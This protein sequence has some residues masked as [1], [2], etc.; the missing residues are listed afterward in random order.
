MS[1]TQVSMMGQKGF[2]D[3][4]YGSLFVGH[5]TLFGSFSLGAVYYTLG[6]ITLVDSSNVSSTVS[7]EKDYSLAFNYSEEFFGLLGTGLSLKYLNSKLVD[8]VSASAF[9]FDAGIQSRIDEGKLALGFAVLNIGSDMKYLD[10]S[11]PLPLT[12][13]I[14]GSYR[15]TFGDAGKAVLALDLVKERESDFKKFIGADYV[16]H[17]LVAVRGGYK[18]GQDNGKISAGIGFTAESFGI[19][20][21]LTSGGLGQVHS[22][23]LT[24]RFGQSAAARQYSSV[25]DERVARSKE[26]HN[27][28]KSIKSPRV[29]VAVLGLNSLGAGENSAALLADGLFLEFSKMDKAFN[30]LDSARVR[31][32]I[33]SSGV[34]LSQCTDIPC[35]QGVGRSLGTDKIVTGLLTLSQGEYSLNVQMLDVES[36]TIE[37]TQAVKASS[38]KDMEYEIRSIVR[39]LAKSV[40]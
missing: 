16:W 40:Q 39:S 31:E 8:S 18:I 29:N 36:G 21:A 32:T 33:R 38:M 24:Y 3:D 27:I 19:D 7:A 1:V 20:Y 4:T 5:P 30:V 22:A 10:A 6:D 26:M 15:L 17:D 28:R 2:A 12:V 9:A 23:S 14:G 37:V 11:E 13:R 34:D 25:M 35:L